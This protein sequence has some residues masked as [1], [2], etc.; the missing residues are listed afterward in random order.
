M[1]DNTIGTIP[2]FTSDATVQPEAAPEEVNPTEQVEEKDTPAPPA[3]TPSD[4]PV[5]EE[6]SAPSQDEEVDRA[7]QGL[8]NERVKLLKE[9]SELKGQRREIKQEQIDRNQAQIDELKDLHPDDVATIERVLRAKGM[10][11]KEEA[12]QMF[13]NDVK[14][15]ELN[16]FLEKYPEYKPENDPSDVNWTTLQRELGFYK[17]PT[18]PRALGE[19]LERAHRAVVKVPSSPSV[20]AQ[21]RQVQVAGVGGGGTQPA[22]STTRLDPAKRQM[23]QGFSEEEIQNIERNLV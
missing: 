22:A 16:R 14:D 9:I 13:Y 2:E 21:K 5:V 18:D 3:E 4:P 17:M 19:I 6:S 11:S 12:Q 15:Q 23:L 7:I 8:Q 10:V 20:A 1:S